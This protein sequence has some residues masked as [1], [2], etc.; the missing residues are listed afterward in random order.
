MNYSKVLRN[1]RYL[2]PPDSNIQT[3]K[4][5]EKKLE[6]LFH[7]REKVEID[8]LL[9]KPFTRI[10]K[11]LAPLA[12]EGIGQPP[13]GFKPTSFRLTTTKGENANKIVRNIDFIC[14]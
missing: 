6:T 2:L 5:N 4:E 7:I 9:K 11:S 8:G 1:P 14:I 10:S 13:D 12:E 3:K